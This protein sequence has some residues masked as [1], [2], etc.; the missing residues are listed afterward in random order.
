MTYALLGEWGFQGDLRDTSGNGHHGTLGR[1]VGSVVTPPSYVTGPQAGT[2]AIQWAE[3]DQYID[4]GATG[5]EPSTEGYAAMAWVKS[6][7]VSGAF[8]GVLARGRGGSSTRAGMQITDTGGAFF[9]MLRW[10]DRLDF[11]N[12]AAI[13]D[14]TWHHLAVVDNNDRGAAYIDGVKVHETTTPASGSPTW[15]SG[16]TWHIGATVNLCTSFAGQ[17]ISGARI[18]GGKLTDADVAAWMATP[19]LPSRIKVWTG[20]AWAPGIAKRWDGTA[21]TKK[22]PQKWTG[23]AWTP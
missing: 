23:S 5:L 15:E 17:A 22:T 21:W 16:F 19:V 1:A 3:N 20:G 12:A 11:G 8:S 4:L 2:K 7:A 18:F 14:G 6:S 9:Y 13:A 10:A